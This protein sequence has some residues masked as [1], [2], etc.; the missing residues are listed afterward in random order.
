MLPIEAALR[1]T[2][3]GGPSLESLC[4]N[5]QDDDLGVLRLYPDGVVFRMTGKRVPLFESLRSSSQDD[6]KDDA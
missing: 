6:G 5:T 4:S 1:M 2:K 3:E